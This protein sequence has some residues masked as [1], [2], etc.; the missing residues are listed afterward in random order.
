MN[1]SNGHGMSHSNQNS[2]GCG[3]GTELESPFWAWILAPVQDRP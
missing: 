1:L 3:E 2:F